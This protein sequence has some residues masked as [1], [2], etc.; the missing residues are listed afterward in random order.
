M[1]F[2]FACPGAIALAVPSLPL[3]PQDAMGPLQACLLG[4]VEGVTEYLPISSTGHLLL[5]QH[6]MGIGQSPETKAAADAYAVCIQLGAILAVVGLYFG[7][8]RQMVRGAMGRDPAGLQLGINVVMGFLPAAIVGLLLERHLKHYLFGLRPIVAAWLVGGVAILLVDRWLARSRRVS[9]RGTELSALSWR[10]ALVIG[11]FQCLAMWP[12]T[13][14]SLVTIL[15]GLFAGLT[16]GA[17][18]EFSFLLGLLTLTASTLLDAAQFGPTIFQLY[19][20]QSPLLGMATAA[21][22]AALAVK[23]MVRYLQSHPLAVF[24]YYRIVLALATA[25][26]MIW[27]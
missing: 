8:V 11:A 22:S 18:V 13:S 3:A 27:K 6:I 12:G 23:W 10:M 26:V 4:I 25:G 14:R 15:G 17:A 21:V 5:A 2:L 24:G 16:L 19:G 1:S 7:R 9:P 20:W